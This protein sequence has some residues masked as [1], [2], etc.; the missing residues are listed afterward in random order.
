LEARALSS[1]A[2]IGL[3]RKSVAPASIA[4]R[5]SARTASEVI[6]TTRACSERGSARR[7]RM[8]SGPPIPGIRRSRRHHAASG[9]PS[10]QGVIVGFQGAPQDAL[11]DAAEDRQA[12]RAVFR[13]KHVH[14][15]VS[16]GPRDR[17]HGGWKN[18]LTGSIMDDGVL[19]AEAPTEPKPHRLPTMRKAPPRRAAAGAPS[20]ELP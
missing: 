3:S 15:V 14:A 10:R 17:Q 18:P 11:H 12:G 19:S 7:R 9:F 2:S 20:E 1:C 16:P 13:H 4:S 5:L 6:V 8:K